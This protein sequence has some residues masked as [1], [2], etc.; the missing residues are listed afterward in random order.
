M[1]PKGIAEHLASRELS[2][3]QSLLWN[4]MKNNYTVHN[5]A[6]ITRSENYSVAQVLVIHRV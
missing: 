4:H 2:E 6:N 1:W 5:T 3:K